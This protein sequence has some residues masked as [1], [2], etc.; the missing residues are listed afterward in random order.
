M[1]RTLRDSKLDTREARLRLKIQTKPFWRLIEPGLHL[2][3]RRLA[4]RAG[5]WC[6]RRYVGSQTY[7]V[8]AINAVA[9]DYREANGDDVLNFKQ[10]QRRALEHKPKAAAGALTVKDALDQYLADL[11]HR[12]RPTQDTRYRVD[13]LIAKELGAVPVEALTSEQL[14]A[15]HAALA[16]S[17]GRYTQKGDAGEARRRRQASANRTLTILRAALNLAYR[18][19]KVSSDA[20]WRRVQIGRASCRER[21]STA[22]GAATI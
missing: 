8:Q 2:G 21:V 3:Y 18:E 13:G 1:A 10:A 5:S 9:D 15:W 11:E 6:V 22:E 17:P 14:R 16:R 4:G 20:Q 12:H 19:G 7:A